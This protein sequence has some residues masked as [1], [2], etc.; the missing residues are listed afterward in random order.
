MD[1]F[2]A[3]A[4]GSGLPAEVALYEAARLTSDSLHD[5]ARALD[6][7]AEH[8]LRFPSSALRIEVE[9]LRVRSLEH[10]GRLDEALSASEALLDAPGGRVLAP[11]LHA[12][13]GRIYGSTRHDCAHAVREYVALLGEPGSAGDDAE[14]RRAACLEQLERPDEARAA[15][16]RYLDRRDPSHAEAAR[17]RLSALGLSAVPPATPAVQER[18]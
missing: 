8:Q 6:L 15:Y 14:F 13:R 2:R 7:L 5:A 9:W 3:I 16:Q 11:K 17:T 4:S 18:P 1:C 10:V 12:L